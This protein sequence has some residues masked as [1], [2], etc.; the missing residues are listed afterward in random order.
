MKGKIMP[1]GVMSLEK[2]YD[3]QNW[4]RGLAN[5]KTHSSK[6]SYEQF[7]FRTLEDLKYVNLGKSCCSPQERQV[8]NHLFKRYRDVFA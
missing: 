6:L 1:K 5:T 2:L 7:N 3:L 4:F 8:L